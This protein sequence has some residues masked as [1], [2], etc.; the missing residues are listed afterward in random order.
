MG[1][2]WKSK[3]K[4]ILLW[5]PTPWCASVCW[6]ARTCLYQL[7]ADTGWSLEYLLGAMDGRARWNI[8]NMCCLHSLISYIYCHPQTDCFVL[9][10]VFSV[11]RHVGCSKPGLKPIQLY[12]RLS[13][14]PLGQQAYHVWLREFLRYYVAAV[15][16]HFYTLSATRVL[17][18]FKELCI[19]RA[20]AE[21]SFTGVVNHHGGV[22]I[23]SSTQILLGC[24]NLKKTLSKTL[25]TT[26][27]PPLMKVYERSGRA[28]DNS[29][30]NSNLKPRHLSGNLKGS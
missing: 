20:A 12:V 13:L 9:S 24:K 17:N 4:D 1:H 21:N 11:A 29:S 16:L 3:D 27:K 18:S 22:Y 26:C 28:R 8:R 7:H 14:R 30:T 15:C 5:I 10:K 19:M 2:C 6:P 25:Y 23:L